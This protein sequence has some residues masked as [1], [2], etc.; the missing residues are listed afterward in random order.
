M[1]AY[2][3]PG[4]MTGQNTNDIV[5]KLV[6]LERRPIKRW[7][8]ENEYAKMQIQIWGEVK[9]LTTNLQTKTRALVSFT[10]PFA[11]KSVSSSVEG[12]ITGEAS[13]A[14]KSGNRALEII[15]MASKHQLSGVEIDTDIRLPEGSFT[16]YSGKS[17][18]TVTFPGGGLSDLT[19]AIKNMAGS[20]VETSVI[21]I[22][23]DSSI[24]TL[25]SVKT[26]K[27]NE[28]QFSDPNGI[29]KLAGLVG[30]NKA[31]SE[32]T[33]QLLSLDGTKAKVWDLSKFKK[34]ELETE[35]I[36]QTEEGI[37]LKPDTAYTIPIAVTEIKERAYLEVEVIGEAPAVMEMGMS[38]EKEGSV[39]NKFLPIN[40]T[41]FKYIF[42][43]GDFASDKNLTGIIV[44]NSATT[45]IQI[46]S[47]TLVTPQAPG[48]AEPLKVLQEAKD[49]KIKIDGVEITRET[50]DGIADVLEGISF[51]VHKVTEEPVTLKI[52]VDHAKGS[53]LIKE[54]VDAYNDLMK[55]SKEVTSVE[56]NGK[57]SD[58]KESDDSKAADIS[59]DFWDNKSKSG[60]LAGENSILR[61][62]ASLKTTANSYYPATK[63][64]GFRVLTDIGISTG[65]VGSNWEKIQDG[66][67]QIDQ[68]KLI[69]VLSE[70]PDGVRDLFAS[71]PNN[72]AKMEEGVGIRLLEILKP[73]NQYASGIVTSKVKLLEESVA[74]NNKK[75]KEHE[76]H[77]ISFEAKLKQR[78]LYM[79][80]G[81]GKNKSVGN[82]LQN[83]MFRG[84]GGE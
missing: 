31:A 9:N 83:N 49:L 13:R 52:H 28:L 42:Q 72:D 58:K 40:K 1:P 70:N 47:V 10:A 53:A 21:K 23:K 75:I 8:T 27:K 35:K 4:L 34:S 5:K 15:E 6:E 62:I 43:V 36:A 14:A 3:M 80:Q 2:T 18:E 65:A 84:N 32:D 45:P 37:F 11:T 12:V 66:L 16:V 29:L 79:E 38:F 64:N 81:V 51:N 25:T 20:L 46:K 69:A 77:L 71:D 7:E 19:S 24:I 73:Y 50:N 44:S 63:E 55:F 68:E 22:D 60:L 39:R 26:G 78:F 76:S 57:I 17:K 61:L 74:G 41:E 33:K 48:T 30:E 59:R 54:W 67:L 82:Y 56:K